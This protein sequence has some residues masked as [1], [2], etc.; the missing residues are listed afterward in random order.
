MKVLFI[1]DL[2]G[3]PGRNALTR[4]LRPIVEREEIDFIIVNGE[5]VAGGFGITEKIAK[6]LFEYGVNV[7]TTGNHVWDKKD[8]V[9]YISQNDRLLRPANYPPGTPGFGSVIYY[10]R[11]GVKV[12]VV[13][14]SGRIFM[15]P[16]DC[17]FR[18]GLAEINRLRQETNIIIVDFH[19]EATSEKV[20]FANFVN[21]KVS[22]VLGTHTHV[23]TADERIF[24]KGTAFITDV[25]MTGPYDSIIGIKIDQIVDKFLTFMPRKYD[26]AK[27][28]EVFCAVIVEIDENTGK[29]LSINRVMNISEQ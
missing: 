27:G 6:E 29:A 26:V 11:F 5:N 25:G 14:V 4:E 18:V 24:S 12:G 2:V 16:V 13:N 1:G 28:R 3:Q 15:A 21:G 10:S 20:A 8:I 7:I 23:Q 17:P 9:G 19:G 22:A